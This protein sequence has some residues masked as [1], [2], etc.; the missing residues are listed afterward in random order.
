MEFRVNKKF[1]HLSELLL[2][3]YDVIV[4]GNRIIDE[5]SKLIHDSI[6]VCS[7]Q[8]VEVFY[9]FQTFSMSVN[10]V[11]VKLHELDTFLQQFKHRNILI[12]VTTLDFSEILLIVKGLYKI[13][14]RLSFSYV[15]PEGYRRVTSALLSE[16][17]FEL[18]NSF[19]KISPIPPFSPLMDGK[20][21]SGHLISFVGYEHSRLGRI[22]SE[23][24]NSTI[25]KFSMVFAVPAFNP[26]WESHS[27]FQHAN[28]LEDRMYDESYFIAA[29]SP[30][31]IFNFLKEEIEPSLTPNQIL[32]I[33]PYSTK[34][35]SVG[36][37]LYSVNRLF[38]A[39]NKNGGA[40]MDKAKNSVSI[41]YD[42]PN[43]SQNSTYGV[44]A[45]HL[46]EVDLG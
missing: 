36:V 29:T 3:D 32:Q 27:I 4:V 43:K 44:G 12:E 26:G 33:A 34:P 23:D 5:R 41:K 8:V 14:R 46:Y 21:I 31:S 30:F 16:H 28:Y 18:S 17:K 13:V 38:D 22:L 39:A 45:V 20:S 9:N 15:E 6:K 19:S 10:G 42:F 2:S 1:N 35:V 11:F 24:E 25:K 7:S 37:V 40:P